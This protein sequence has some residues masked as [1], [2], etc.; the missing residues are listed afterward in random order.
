MRS[1]IRGFTLIEVMVVMV[2]LGILAAIIVPKIINRPDQ[3]RIVAAKND[4]RSIMSALKLYRLDNGQYPTTQQGLMALVQKP[5]SSPVPPNWH[6]Y[7]DRMPKDPWGRPYHYLNPGIH[8]SID[9]WTY[10]ADGK[11]GGTGKNAE[12]GSWQV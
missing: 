2:I 3:A 12:I 8:G 5:S 7:L 9:V 4:I 10:G 11:P 6:H 1:R